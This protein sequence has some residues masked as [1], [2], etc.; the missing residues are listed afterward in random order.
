MMD[1]K[2]ISISKE[3]LQIASK[4]VVISIYPSLNIVVSSLYL[5]CL[6]H[7][8]IDLSRDN[9]KMFEFIFIQGNTSIS[10]TIEYV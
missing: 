3:Y 8:S 1:L 7:N 10:S 5:A 2:F 6:T 9:K 4:F